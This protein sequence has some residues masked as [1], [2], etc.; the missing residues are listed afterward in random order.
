MIFNSENFLKLRCLIINEFCL[1]DHK[2][3]DVQVKVNILHTPQKL[4]T[5]EFL[6]EN[7]ERK[8]LSS[9]F[10]NHIKK[11]CESDKIKIILEKFNALISLVIFFEE[12]I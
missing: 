5:I 9:K 6:F 12:Q 11:L 2:I 4:T 8:I 7:I 1:T 10:I 3:N